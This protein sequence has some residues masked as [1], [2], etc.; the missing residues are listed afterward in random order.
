[1]TTTSP[2]LAAVSALWHRPPSGRL[3]IAA[4][5]AGY[6]ALCHAIFVFWPIDL[7]LK[8]G[9]IF[10]PRF[11]DDGSYNGFW[12]IWHLA[13]VGLVLAAVFVPERK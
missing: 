5:M 9:V 1:M 8:A 11:F 7:W 4:A 6:D 10:W 13:I 12:A 3:L 2:R